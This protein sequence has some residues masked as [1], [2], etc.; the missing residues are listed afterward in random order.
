MITDDE[1]LALSQSGFIPGPG[2]V[3]EN[4]LH[5][6]SSTK[7]A[8]LKLGVSAIPE[9]HWEWVGAKLRKLFGFTPDSL[10][11]FYSNR[12]LSPWQG[13]AAWVERGQIIA[14]Q[15]RNAFKKGSFLR[16]YQRSE[17]LSHEA[18]HAARSAFPKDPWDEFFAYMVSEKS[19]R[20]AL[21]PIIQRPWEVWPF[22]VFCVLGALDAIFFLGAAAWI[23]A[24]FFRLI[25][26]HLTLTKASKELQ[27]QMSDDDA[28]ALLLRLTGE[29]IQSLSKGKEIKISEDLRGRL[30]AI[31]KEGT[32]G[33]KNHC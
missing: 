25:R 27:K 11:A 14:I 29:E 10:P 7:Q 13:A 32:N 20:R 31:Y 19:W 33:R 8:F 3:E 6:V 4:F 23:G 22:L 28:R 18:V 30:I 26:A 5:R 1:L 15:L 16:M 24:G 12:S 21:G 17:I 9:S 2:E